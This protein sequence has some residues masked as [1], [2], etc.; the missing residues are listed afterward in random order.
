VTTVATIVKKVISDI[1]RGIGEPTAVIGHL[2][3]REMMETKNVTP[4]K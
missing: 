1:L 2:L 4:E 3:G